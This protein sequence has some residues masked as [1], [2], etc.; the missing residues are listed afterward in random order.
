M[1]YTPPVYYR[2]CSRRSVPPSILTRSIVNSNAAARPRVV[3]ACAR[4]RL[5][6]SARPPV[7]VAPATTFILVMKA[8]R[9]AMKVKRARVYID[10][11]AGGFIC[12]PQ[13][14]PTNRRR[15]TPYRTS[16]P[17]RAHSRLLFFYFF[18]TAKIFLNYRLHRR[19]KWLA[20]PYL[21]IDMHLRKEVY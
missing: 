16:F 1:N 6:G 12:A 17:G 11:G 15:K 13:T 4:D 14:R 8:A 18:L 20:S 7:W 2:K 10:V 19:A 9:R 21:E 3:R 5:E